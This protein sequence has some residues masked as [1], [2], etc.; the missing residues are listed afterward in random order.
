MTHYVLIDHYTGYVW[1]EADADDPITACV[2]VD[3]EIDRTP[4]E[5][6]YRRL[7]GDS[8]YH[9]YE[10]PADW[11]EVD[12]GQSRA[13]IERVTSTCRKIAEVKTT[14]PSDY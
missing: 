6:E 13:E 11:K 3:Q 2:K 1:G 14:F 12:D 5:Y 7:D 4:R 10:A 9:V 8:G